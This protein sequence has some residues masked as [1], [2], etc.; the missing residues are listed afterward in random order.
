MNDIAS[1]FQDHLTFCQQSLSV[2]NKG[3]EIIP[4]LP[5]PA[6]I[7]LNKAIEQAR[8]E[9]RPP[10][11]VYLKARQVFVSTGTAGRFFHETAFT[12]GQHTMVV[13]HEL[14]SARNLW[15]YYDL[16]QSTYK[17]FGARPLGAIHLDALSK[18]SQGAGE[19]EWANGSWI[20]IATADNV[21]TGRSFT[22]QR[23]HLSEYAFYRDAR[24]LMAALIKMVPDSLDSIVV[25]ESTANGVGN[26]FWQLWQVA[27][28]PA[29]RSEWI[30]LFCAWHEHPEYQR[31][32]PCPKGEFFASLDAEERELMQQFRL[33][34]EQL[35]W[36][37]WS[38]HTEFRGDAELFRQECPSTPEEAFRTSG[39]PVFSEKH[40]ARMPLIREAIAGRLEEELIGTQRRISFLPV[41]RGE[42][43]VYKKPEAGHLYAIGADTAMGRDLSEGKGTADPDYSV[44]NVLDI[45]SGEQ[46]ANLRGRIDPPTFGAYLCTLGRWFNFAFIVLEVNYTGL[47][48]VPELLRQ[49][50]PP[51]MLYHR[52]VTPDDLTHMGTETSF[53]RVGWKTTPVTRPQMLSR[54]AQAIR[55]MTVIIRCPQTLQE[56]R[57]FVYHPDGKPAGQQGCHDDEVFSI[58]LA[59]V[60]LE[61]FPRQLRSGATSRQQVAAVHKYGRRGEQDD[62]SRPSHLVRL[63]R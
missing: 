42:L 61:A 34:L 13:A 44:A 51:A 47:G 38:I 25:V 63:R 40:L 21:E 53:G 36:R 12:P 41:E 17:P 19:L 4:Y 59:L 31:R 23:L 30:P 46:V 28:D 9:R 33:S 11:I 60:G 32:L 62:D 50:Y 54:L 52:P 55:E 24:T 45:D 39:R 57:T 35:A 16:F 15:G 26:D 18:R 1:G 56:C 5:A 29:A 58:G 14:K 22:V 27:N 6:Q 7:K 49:G 2:R 43:T 20:K 3:G 48:T 37:R 10:R 8:R